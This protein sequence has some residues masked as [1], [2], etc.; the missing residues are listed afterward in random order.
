MSIAGPARWGLLLAA[1]MWLPF[2]PTVVVEAQQS[3]TEAAPL[4]ERNPA[5]RPK[6]PEETAYFAKLDA[7][8][9]QYGAYEKEANAY[10]DLIAEKRQLR[11]QRRAGGQSVGL[12]HYVLDQPPV[13][14][15]P[16]E[17]VPPPSLVRERPPT[18][19][20]QP[21]TPIPVLADFLE[22][23][24][25]HF[26]FE[27]EMPA[28]EADFKRAY[29]LAAA[30]VG[31]AKDQA[32]RIYGFE[33]SGNGR[34]D[35][36]AGLEAPGAKRRAISTA[37]GYNQLLIT[38]TISILAEH[39]DDLV[40]AIT[41]RANNAP[42]RRAGIEAKLAVLRQMIRFAQSVPKRWSAQD[43]LART[44]KGWG[45]HAL[46]LDIDV[47]PI[48]QAQKLANSLSFASARASART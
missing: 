47:G 39:D 35:V 27:P 46:N 33:A 15:G 9:S 31:I 45:V 2:D 7:Y 42:E 32:V 20:G 48:L 26:G 19:P 41:A 16:P 37:I 25:A 4:P 28:S 36:Q 8:Q 5:P 29:A 44:P 3:A 21:P 14:R 23:A 22:Q 18:E 30:K 12:E 17:P 11:R 6:T 40:G 38:N 13:Y 34:Y 24:K 10:W 1:V 43:E